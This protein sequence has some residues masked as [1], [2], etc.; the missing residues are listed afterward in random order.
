MFLATE[1]KEVLRCALCRSA[2]SVFR[3]H[4]H[5]HFTDTA[6]HGYNEQIADH[7]LASL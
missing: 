6:N 5:V 4:I 7:R 1:E 2:K 3:M